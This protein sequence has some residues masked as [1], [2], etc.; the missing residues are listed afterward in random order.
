M[1][2]TRPLFQAADFLTEPWYPGDW[3]NSRSGSW[4][5][6]QQ[7]Y[8]SYLNAIGAGADRLGETFRGG[9]IGDAFRS[10]GNMLS[11]LRDRFRPQAPRI[12]AIRQDQAEARRQAAEDAYYRNW[13]QSGAPRNTGVDRRRGQLGMGALGSA[14]DAALAYYS[15]AMRNRGGALM[16]R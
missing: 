3:Y 11:N 9:G 2:W 4:N 8:S 15:N 13:D 7:A 16:E 6:P 5:N 10:G 1:S 14:G 12:N